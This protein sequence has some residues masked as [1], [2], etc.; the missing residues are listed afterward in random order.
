MKKKLIL[1]FGL[2]SLFLMLISGCSKQELSSQTIAE[3]TNRDKLGMT[4]KNATFYDSISIELEEV[5]PSSQTAHGSVQ[6][7]DLVDYFATGKI[8]VD[9]MVTVELEF[10]VQKID[11]QWQITSLEPIKEYIRS[12]AN[13]LLYEAIEADGGINIEFNPREV[14]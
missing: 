1:F 10:P 14:P 6:I 9:N 3:L 4:E 2:V 7:P 8:S 12:Q 11:G 5:D 13:N